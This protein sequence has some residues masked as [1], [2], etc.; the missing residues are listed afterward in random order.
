MRFLVALGLSAIAATAV[1]ATPAAATGGLICKTADAQPLEI[2][3][4]F[5]HVAGAPLILTRLREGDRD[6]P[7]HAPQWWLN[8]D[9]MR[10]LLTDRDSLQ[11][12]A[13]VQT[14]RNGATFDGRVMRNGES[15]W[16]RCKQD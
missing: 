5:G 4:G 16:I 6:V 13:E 15:R 12:E 14:V 2:A 10:L 7:V 8:D 1:T 9:E 11:V 3:L